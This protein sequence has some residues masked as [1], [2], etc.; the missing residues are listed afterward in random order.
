[1][2]RLTEHFIGSLIL[3]I[4][5]GLADQ[6]RVKLNQVKAGF[7]VKGVFRKILLIYYSK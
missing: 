2:L 6:V 3:L 1:M 5:K 4:K 7:S